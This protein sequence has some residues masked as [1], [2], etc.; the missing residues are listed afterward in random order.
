M[1]VE[2]LN[3]K[4]I[5]VAVTLA[6]IAPAAFADGHEQARRLL[7]PDITPAS[8]GAVGNANSG[9]PDAQEQARR[10]LAGPHAPVDGTEYVGA[11]LIISVAEGDGHEQAKRLL[12]RPL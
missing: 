3:L 4:S 5:A 6:V 9:S 8:R 12:Q 11:A 1:E 2:M 7:S 10:L